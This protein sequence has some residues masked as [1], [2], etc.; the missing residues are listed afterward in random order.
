MRVQTPLG[1]RVIDH[2]IETAKGTLVA[3]E[4]KSGNAVRSAL[5]IQKDLL[6]ASG[7]YQILGDLRDYTGRLID[8]MVLQL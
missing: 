3:V 2:L 8:T 1:I 6:I 4:V 7:N 5:Q